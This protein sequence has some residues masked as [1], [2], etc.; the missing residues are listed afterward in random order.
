MGLSQQEQD[1]QKRAYK[2]DRNARALIAGPQGGKT[3]KQREAVEEERK[4]QQMQAQAAQQRAYFEQMQLRVRQVEAIEAIAEA[5]FVGNEERI[6]A[7]RKVQEE[8]QVSQM[9][10]QKRL[11]AEAIAAAEK[12]KTK[13]SPT[14]D[15]GTQF[16]DGSEL[17]G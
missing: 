6:I 1:L 3:A 12:A 5:L 11:H 14:N 7:W 17:D 4:R 16:P 8:K 2:G 15:S 13:R 9:E 10:E